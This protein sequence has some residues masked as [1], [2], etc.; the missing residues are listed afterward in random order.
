MG[1]SGSK[2]CRRA[3]YCKLTSVYRLRFFSR[4]NKCEMQCGDL[5][6]LVR[7]PMRTSHVL[8]AKT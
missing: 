3:L 1:R 6:K 5:L 7:K 8:A 2:I 4:N